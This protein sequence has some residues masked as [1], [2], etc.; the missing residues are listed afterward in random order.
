MALD[1]PIAATRAGGIP[2]MLDQGAGLLSPRRRCRP[3]RPAR[4]LDDP[5]LRASLIACS[6]GPGREF[7]ATAMAEG[8]L[9]V[10]RSIVETVDL[11]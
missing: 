2:E 3:G 10:Y 5:A 9:A 6:P 1:V 11:K 8:V 4:L 7:S